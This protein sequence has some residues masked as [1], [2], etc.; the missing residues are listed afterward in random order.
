[1]TK[2]DII[3]SWPRNCDYP[4]WRKMIREQRD[5]FNEVVVVFTETWQ[6]DDYRQFVKDAMFQ[7]HVLFVQSPQIG[8]GE[9]WR[10]IAI[11]AALLHSIHSE[12]IWFTEQDFFPLEG[13]WEMVESESQMG[14]KAI[15]VKDGN[16]L[17]PCSLFLKRELLNTLDKNFGIVP[18]K[19]DH[20]GLIQNQLE[21]NKTPIGIIPEKYW[22]HMAGLSHN[23]RLLEEQGSPNH[24]ISGFTKYVT[25]CL[26]SGLSISPKHTQLFSD[27]LA[28]HAE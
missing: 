21:V 28:T 18:D 22:Y 8:E 14:V 15:G 5:R 2:P 20:F 11:H 24:D 25:Q 17:H 23:M 13:F 10:D 12:W 6:G 3:I 1:M 27:Y 4:L 16:R 26:E 7:D 9:D 19:L